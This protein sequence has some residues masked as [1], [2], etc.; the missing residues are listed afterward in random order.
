MSRKLAAVAVTVA[1]WVSCSQAAAWVA[2][3]DGPGGG[4]DEAIGVVLAGNAAY[5]AG[6][7]VEAGG[8][9]AFVVLKYDP[10]TGDLLLHDRYQA[11]SGYPATASSVRATAAGNIYVAGT[12]D[13]EDDCC[14]AVAKWDPDLAFVWAF[15]EESEDAAEALALATRG[16]T[17]YAAGF[18][19]AGGDDDYDFL[20]CKLK[21]GE[22]SSAW[23]SGYDSDEEDEDVAYG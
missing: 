16:D 14:F 11:E 23:K 6:T 3:Y 10:A 21:P 18:F 1:V 7:Q 22:G 13:T 17:A 20:T 2:R 12:A 4:Y 8:S 9:A 15:T 19:D 5:V